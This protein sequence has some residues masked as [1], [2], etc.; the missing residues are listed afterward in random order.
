MSLSWFTR[1]DQKM[2][3]SLNARHKPFSYLGEMVVW[4]RNNIIL[5]H[6]CSWY[7]EKKY[8]AYTQWRKPSVRARNP[9]PYIRQFWFHKYIAVRHSWFQHAI[10]IFHHFIVPGHYGNHLR[11]RNFD[12]QN[13]F[14]WYDFHR[15]SAKKNKC[16][17][18]K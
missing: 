16:R 8:I 17:R 12:C 3:C 4:A 6:I 11:V 10:N 5:L 7:I 14:V 1:G 9:T 13:I 18:K 2:H 15:W